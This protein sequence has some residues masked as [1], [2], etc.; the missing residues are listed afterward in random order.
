M[1][2]VIGTVIVVIV[3]MLVGLAC[4]DDSQAE[5]TSAARVVETATPSLQPRSTAW[6]Q[7]V[8]LAGDCSA[9]AGWWVAESPR[10][11]G[12]GV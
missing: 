10:L 9:V 6:R 12:R 5:R 8:A 4:S 11:H 7:A 3:T 1:H 2:R